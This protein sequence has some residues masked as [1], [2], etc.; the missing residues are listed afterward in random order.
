VPRLV[1]RVLPVVLG[2]TFL[3]VALV[4][5]AAPKELK[6]RL[7]TPGATPAAAAAA[8]HFD[9]QFHDAILAANASTL[10]AGDRIILGD[11]LLQAGQEVGHNAGVCTITDPAGEMI[12]EVVYTLPEGT[13]ATQF[14]NTPP[15]AKT[16]AVVGGTGRYAGARG[17]G[18]LL[19]HADQTGVLDFQLLP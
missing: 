16:F 13:I 12:C 1:T 19:E 17:T 15:P 7:A 9:V 10:A 14:L 6:D 4:G 5:L 11:R 2:A 8:L 18:T 3:G